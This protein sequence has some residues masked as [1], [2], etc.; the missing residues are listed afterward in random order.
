MDLRGMR[1][2]GIKYVLNATA[3]LDNFHEKGN[4]I[5]YLKINVKDKEG[6]DLSKFFAQCIGFIE[7]GVREG[8]IL[9]HCIA[10]ASRSVTF[11]LCYL[12]SS[13][14]ERLV[15][16][17]AYNW[18]KAR[19]SVAHPNNSFLV[20]LAKYE[21]ALHDGKSSIA[22]GKEKIWNCYELNTLKKEA[23]GHLDSK[24]VVGGGC[25]VM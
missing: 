12:M 8:G 19:R 6:V 20:Q 3:Q 4:G 9:V 17:D 16:K 24:L 10:G 11:V 5:T 21:M 23:K 14:G 15:L 7:E 13:C 18:T 2:K 22:R 25:S 1:Q